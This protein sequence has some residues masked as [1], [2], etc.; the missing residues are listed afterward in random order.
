MDA[1]DVESISSGSD[2][3]IHDDDDDMMAAGT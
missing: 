3:Q 2:G 1:D